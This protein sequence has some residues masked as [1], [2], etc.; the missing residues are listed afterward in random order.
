MINPFRDVDWKPD[1]AARRRFAVSLI[2]GFPAIALF[3]LALSRVTTG[4]W[5]TWPM[6][7]GAI[8]FTAGGLLW[9]LPSIARPLYL[10]WYFAACCIGI[11][12]ANLLFAAL[13]YLIITPLGL[14]L[15]AFG[16]L[17][18]RKQPQTDHTTSYWRDAPK[19][20]DPTQYYRQF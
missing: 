10:V 8:G 7:L 18:V 13:F 11:V 9:L 14:L 5:Q 15:R 19:A 1:R 3:F 20:C 17:S 4:Q 12:V 2:I 6:W 16:A